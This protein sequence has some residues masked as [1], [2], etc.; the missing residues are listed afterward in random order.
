[1]RSFG[2]KAIG[3][4][5]RRARLRAGLTQAGL[6]E[7]AGISDETVSRIERGAYEPAVSTMVA[8]ADALGVTLDVLAGRAAPKRAR[9]RGSPLVG[10]LAD[11][12]ELLTP[13]AQSALLQVA[14]LLP[15]RRRRARW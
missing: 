14:K 6:A 15:A 9:A 7:A 11:R 1:M 2:T 5:V 12:A 8:L 10:R 13:E 3:G 4:H